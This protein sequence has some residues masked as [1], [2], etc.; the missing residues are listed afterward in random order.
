MKYHP[1]VHHRRSQRLKGYDYTQAGAYFVT[2]CCYDMLLRF[3]AVE[4]EG[5]DARMALNDFGLVAYEEWLGLASRFPNVELD[6]FQVM[7][8]HMHAVFFLKTIFE[9]VEVH[10][11]A[12]VIDQ[13]DRAGASPAPT[14]SDIVGAYKSIVANKCLDIF[15]EINSETVKL[16]N[17]SMGKLWQRNFY[18]SVI[19]DDQAYQNIASYIINNPKNWKQDKFYK[20][21]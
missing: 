21:Y 19:S 9:P 17:E 6:V 2:I 4:G 11:S 13:R 3:G 1:E 16:Y 7:P 10:G 15:K 20:E 12:G 5:E 14:V 8:N 18:D